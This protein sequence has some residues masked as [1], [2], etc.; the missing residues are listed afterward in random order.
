MIFIW[1]YTLFGIILMEE[2]KYTIR[3]AEH[4]SLSF[5]WQLHSLFVN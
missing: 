3:K 1:N 4:L 5:L 2:V